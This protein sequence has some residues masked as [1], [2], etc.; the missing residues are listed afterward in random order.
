MTISVNGEVIPEKAVEFE[1]DRLVRFYA[2]HLSAEELSKQMDLLKKKARDQ[3]IGSKLLIQ[4]ARRLEIP[5]QQ[6]EVDS[7]VNK[8]IANAGGKEKFDQLMKRQNT[9]LEQLVAG[10]ELGVK[11]DKLV[12]KIASTAGDPTEEEMVAHFEAHSAEYAKA[13]QAQ[14]S[15][16][17]IKAASGRKEDIETARSRL[18][19]IRKDIEEGADFADQAAAHSDCQSGRKSGGSLGW[20]SRGMT[21]P[22]FD[23]VV[24]AQKVGELSGVV[25]TPLGFHIIKKTAGESG[26]QV[27]YRDV[28]DKI[29]DFLRHAKRGAAVTA[30]VEELR[31]NAKIEEE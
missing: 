6:A 31:G 25:E 26:G 17:L 4:E 1:L 9:N 30:Y 23:K 7:R 5:V 15:H 16:I 12:A 24:F 3:A 20:V 18:M 8:L 29:R 11:V 14:V 28:A 2:E 13:E 22:E 10:V 19:Q 27:A 21:L